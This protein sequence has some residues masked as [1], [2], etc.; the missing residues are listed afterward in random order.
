LKNALDSGERTRADD[1]DD[2]LL[3]LDLEPWRLGLDPWGLGLD[4]WGL[5]PEP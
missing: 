4:P 3:R 5:G 1:D 2:R